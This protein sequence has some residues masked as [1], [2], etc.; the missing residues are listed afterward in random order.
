MSC[1][2]SSPACLPS[3]SHGDE[4]RAA[5]LINCDASRSIEPTR[6]LFSPSTTAWSTGIFRSYVVGCRAPKRE[7]VTQPGKGEA[8]ELSTFPS[9]PCASRCL[10]RNIW[11]QMMS[12]D[13]K[14]LPRE[15]GGIFIYRLAK[16]PGKTMLTPT[17]NMG[18]VYPFNHCST[19]SSL[20]LVRFPLFVALKWL[21]WFS[22][23]VNTTASQLQYLLLGWLNT[24]A[25]MQAAP[26]WPAGQGFLSS[27]LPRTR[28][29]SVEGS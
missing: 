15:T 4:S 6:N 28:K 20:R 10:M 22:S 9:F 7:G 13:L 3:G 12:S 27:S 18:N 19:D 17:W 26:F 14:L 21:Q 8:P 24:L 23:P 16:S 2:L 1:P 25:A 29:R 5:A 11:W